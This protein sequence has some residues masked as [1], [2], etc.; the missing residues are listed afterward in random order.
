[1]ARSDDVGTWGEFEWTIFS[2]MIELFVWTTF[3]IFYFGWPSPLLA[4]P[5]LCH[6]VQWGYNTFCTLQFISPALTATKM[7]N[8]H[9]A[10][11]Q[12]R[13]ELLS[14]LWIEVIGFNSAPK[15]RQFILWAQIPYYGKSHRL[16]SYRHPTM[17]SSTKF[18]FSLIFH[19]RN[20]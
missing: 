5:G 15:I 20:N 13:L 19:L 3:V 11:K 14:L 6:A 12:A 18:Q 17:V 4:L 2:Y 16:F 1:M 10:M 8:A 7:K 9:N